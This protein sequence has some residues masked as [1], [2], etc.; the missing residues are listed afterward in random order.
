MSNSMLFNP[1]N[2]MELSAKVVLHPSQLDND[3]YNN[4]KENLS[5][6]ILNRCYK[7][8]GL[9]TKIYDIKEFKGGQIFNEDIEGKVQYDVKFDN[10]KG[11]FE[12][13]YYNDVNLLEKYKERFKNVRYAIAPDYSEI[14]DILSLA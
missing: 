2:T 5:I 9:I 7:N 12:A 4:L 10:T 1:K 14:G 6:R 11:I 13:I 3:I 8:F